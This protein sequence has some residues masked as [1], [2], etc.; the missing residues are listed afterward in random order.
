[1]HKILQKL[2][3]ILFICMALSAQSMEPCHAQLTEARNDYQAQSNRELYKLGPA[4]AYTKMRKKFDKARDPIEI[5]PY[6]SSEIAGLVVAISNVKDDK[7]EALKEVL[8]M[9]QLF[10]GEVTIV[11]TKIDGQTAVLKIVPVAN[12]YLVDEK[13]IEYESANII[14][15]YE[16]GVWKFKDAKKVQLNPWCKKA[17]TN[18]PPQTPCQATLLGKKYSITETTQQGDSFQF[19]LESLSSQA[20]LLLTI[21]ARELSELLGLLR[22]IERSGQNRKVIYKRPLFKQETDTYEVFPTVTILNIDTDKIL[23]S[24]KTDIG[25]TII[26]SDY[27]KTGARRNNQKTE[28]ANCSIFLRLPD[29]YKSFLEGYFTI[30]W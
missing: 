24:C 20:P 3:P 1:M 13:R 23:F 10:P 29:Q 14:M 21:S 19:R 18:L 28:T 8:K 25:L 2:P 15:Q 30:G 16:G 11:D 9:T 17:V 4:D 7:G 6:V 5:A 22:K 12:N 27:Q 26:I